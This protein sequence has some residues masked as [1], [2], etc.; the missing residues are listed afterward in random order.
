MY[1]I[2]VTVLLVKTFLVINRLLVIK[3]W[4]GVKSLI[5]ILYCGGVDTPN[6]IVHGSDA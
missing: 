2:C 3:F 1:K 6:R 5:Q 4:W